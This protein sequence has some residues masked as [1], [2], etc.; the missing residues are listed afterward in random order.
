MGGN[1]T[2]IIDLDQWE[3][4][5]AWVESYHRHLSAG[6]APVTVLPDEARMRR[7]TVQEAAALQSFPYT[8]P[9]QGPQSAVFRQIGNAVP[10]FLGY[11]VA[12][13][14]RSVLVPE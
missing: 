11:A 7:L 13:A 10:P 1:H 9:W 5:P 2:P 12:A 8:M 14:V 4:K 6:G 3:G